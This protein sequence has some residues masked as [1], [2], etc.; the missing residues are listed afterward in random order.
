M[1]ISLLFPIANGF[2]LF[3]YKERLSDRHERRVRE[4]YGG[5]Y[6]EYRFKSWLQYMHAS[7]FAVRRLL[8]IMIL[9]YLKDSPS[10]Q[11]VAFQ[12]LNFLVRLLTLQGCRWCWSSC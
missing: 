5:L 8:F 10:V 12:V 1:C 4:Q 3:T 7:F 9:V 11:L 6:E 2:F